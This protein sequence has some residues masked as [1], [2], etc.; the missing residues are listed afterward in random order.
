MAHIVLQLFETWWDR[1]DRITS[2]G[3]P[4]GHPDYDWWCAIKKLHQDEPVLL[5]LLI[6]ALQEEHLPIG[7]LP[8]PT[9]MQL[10]R[11]MCDFTHVYPERTDTVIYLNEWQAFMRTWYQKLRQLRESR[12]L[13]RSGETCQ[14]ATGGPYWWAGYLDM[15][16]F[17]DPDI[18]ELPI[19]VHQ[20]ER[21]P[22]LPD[23]SPCWWN[24]GTWWAAPKRAY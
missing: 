21:F 24:L 10:R 4:P 13:Y 3:L 6:K 1:I 16:Y 2:G 20:G 7:I 19:R 14:P 5:F 12:L 18:V 23:G 9:L 8:K 17:P 15:R 11:I 22:L